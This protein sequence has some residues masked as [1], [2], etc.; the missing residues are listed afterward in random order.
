MKQMKKLSA[1]AAGSMT[2]ALLLGTSLVQ[3]EELVCIDE[4]NTVTG[5]KGLEVD[6]VEFDR[7][8]ID[9]DFIWTTGFAIYG[10]EL[11]NLPF[12]INSEDDSGATYIAINRTL[13]AQ[14]TIPDFAGLDG[15]NE[16]YIG[17]E[18]EK[19]ATFG[20]TAGWSGANYQDPQKGWE[21]CDFNKTDGCT[22]LGTMIRAAE[23]HYVYADLSPAVSGATC[24]G[25]P[26][27]PDSDFTITPGITGSWYLKARD[28]EGYNIEIVGDT[29][30]PQLLAY[31]YTYD[32][33]GNQMWLVGSGPVNG[34]TAVVPVQVTS[35]ALYGDAFDKDDV[36]RENWGTLTFTFSSCTAGSV[37]RASTMGFGTTTYD[38]QRLTSVIGLSC[39]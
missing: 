8:V 20:A 36:V 19:E 9:V 37:V 13:T 34:D 15:K 7:I 6:T 30:D 27:P 10:S 11:D 4:N 18:K 23:E 39:P 22:G 38:I 5:I 35:G 24:S 2:I 1:L 21:P 17:A 25:G 29:F 16:Y 31:F 14:P 33:A 28:G 32:N 26:A 3:A 12:G